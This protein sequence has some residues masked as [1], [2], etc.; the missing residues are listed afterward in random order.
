MGEHVDRFPLFPLGI[1]ALAGKAGRT[2]VQ[3]VGASLELSAGRAWSGEPPSS[4]LVV[5]GRRLER[6]SLEAAFAGCAVGT[7]ER[8]SWV[9]DG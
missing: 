3:G 8:V 5:I 9:E 1:V 7:D 4:R 2:I 6:A